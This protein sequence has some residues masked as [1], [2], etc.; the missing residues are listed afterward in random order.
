M[1][2]TGSTLPRPLYSAAQSRQLD[3]VAIEEF[4]VSGLCLMERAGRAAYQLLWARWPRAR[5]LVVVCGRGNNGGDGLVL[6][7]LA[8][9]DGFRVRVLRP[10][11]FPPC[12]G[13]AARVQQ[14]LRQAGL[15]LEDFSPERFADAE[16][17][18]DALL[19]TGLDRA[20]EGALRTAIDALNAQAAPVL[21]LDLPTG[22]HADTGC[23]LG[24]AVYAQATLSFLSV[25]QGQV[26]GAGPRCCGELYFCDLGLPPTLFQ[27]LPA[28]VQ[29]MALQ[30]L[31]FLLPPRPRDAHKG[32]FGHVLVVGADQGFVGAGRLAAGAAARSGA[33]LVSLATRAPAAAAA[34]PAEIMV[35]LVTQGR[36]LAPLLAQASVLA[37]GPG[38]GRSDWALDLLGR[39]LDS[40]LPQV[41]DADALNLLALEPRRTE[42]GILSPH[43]GEAARLLQCSVADVQADRLSAVR[44]LWERYGGVIVLKG[45]GTLVCDSTGTDLA[46]AGNPGLAT[47]GM[48]DV[49]TGV[50]AGLW[51]QGMSAGEAARLG[52][53]L[54]AAAG[55]AAAA[56]EGERGLQAADLMPWLQRLANP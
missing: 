11:Q 32:K 46:D 47:G 48:G 20:P 2:L 19:G 40:P 50:M 3:Q 29:R 12:S 39:V 36:A 45:A 56:Q 25:K 16:V 6:A 14:R 54:H 9:R 31:E 41:L 26:T 8:H 18:V 52:V 28:A 42:H 35:H 44:A 51:A 13:A 21:S 7:R 53:C 30:H 10:A 22:L 24:R 38:L 33:G 5:R 55:D 49:L 4:G 34:C 43:P 27:R 15:E 37:V 17:L 1:I 23:V